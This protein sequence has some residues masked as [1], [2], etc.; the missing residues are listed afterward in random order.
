[1]REAARAAGLM[2]SGPAELE[3]LA[4]EHNLPPAKVQPKR[5]SLISAP[6]WT[7]ETY[8]RVVA[9]TQEHGKPSMGRVLKGLAADAAFKPH[10]GKAPQVVQVA[11]QDLTA[12]RPEE[13]QERARALKGFDEYAVLKEASAFLASEFACPVEV[14]TADNPASADVR[15]QG[16]A[17]QAAP[18]RPGVAIDY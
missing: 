9:D 7:L 4:A 13:V 10:M 12:R 1:V 14:L 16:K 11:V 6:A 15:Y 2:F 3:L 17:E 5:V 18:L 8:G